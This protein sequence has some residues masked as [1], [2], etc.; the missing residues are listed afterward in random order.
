[1]RK[2]DGRWEHK[3]PHAKSVNSR[4][5]PSPSPAR[6]YSR[7]T[8]YTRYPDTLTIALAGLRLGFCVI[9]TWSRILL[10]CFWA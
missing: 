7:D 6:N 4:T 2:S 3:D 10:K 9:C 1:M 8:L 5:K